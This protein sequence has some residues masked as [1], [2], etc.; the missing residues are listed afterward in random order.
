MFVVVR[1]LVVSMVLVKVYQ[2]VCGKNFCV[3]FA[4]CLLC[5]GLCFGFSLCF[6]LCSA[7]FGVICK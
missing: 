7:G 6:E 2:S 1:V 3:C 4:S 5:F